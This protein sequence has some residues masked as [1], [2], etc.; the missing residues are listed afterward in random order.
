MNTGGFE[1]LKQ[2]KF[3]DSLLYAFAQAGVSSSIFYL[4]LTLIS[5]GLIYIRTRSPS[6]VSLSLIL[7]GAIILPYVEP[8]VALYFYGIIVVGFAL[9]VYSLARAW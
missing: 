7:L 6:M 8:T 3:F 5:S 2:G 9:G 4:F 1:L